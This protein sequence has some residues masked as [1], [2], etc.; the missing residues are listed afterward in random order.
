[1]PVA[2]LV[3]DLEL[4]FNLQVG[5][6]LRFSEPGGFFLN[7]QV[8]ENL[9]FSEPGENVRQCFESQNSKE[10]HKGMS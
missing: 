9:R 5:G 1:M 6:N 3:L 10:N 7:L 8:G 2:F 4:F